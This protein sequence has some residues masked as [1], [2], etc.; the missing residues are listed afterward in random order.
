MNK[1][2]NINMNMRMSAIM[3]MLAGK[4]GIPLRME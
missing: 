3:V 1:S 2:F 4:M